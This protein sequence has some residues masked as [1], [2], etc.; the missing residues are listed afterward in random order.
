MVTCLSLIVPSKARQFDKD[1]S[2]LYLWKSVHGIQEF[3]IFHNY[4]AAL[5]LCSASVPFKSMR[6]SSIGGKGQLFQL[7]VFLVPNNGDAWLSLWIVSKYVTIHSLKL[8]ITK[9]LL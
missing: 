1:S 7:K 4:R 6:V 3:F 9:I 2:E 5:L 8:D